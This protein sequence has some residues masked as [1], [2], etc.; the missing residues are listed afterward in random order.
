[1]SDDDYI[2]KPSQDIYDFYNGFIFSKDNFVFNK[3]I[4]KVEIY[5]LIKL[6]VGDIVEFGVFK[7]SGLA[8]WM[9]L[10]NLYEPHSLMKIIGFDYFDAQNLL[11]DLNGD[12]KKIMNYVV[13]R[14]DHVDL[15]KETI[16]KKLSNINSNSYIL[17][18]GEAVQQCSIYYNKNQGARIKLLYM[19][20]DLGEP[21]YEIL[22]ILWEKVVKDGIIVFDEYGYHRFDESNG[23]D[24]FLKDMKGKYEIFNTFV[25]HPSMYI[26]KIAY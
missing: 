22:K 14:V 7:G 1:M 11:N 2:V 10:K 23:V 5:S 8:L 24:K 25:N 19:D 9:K 17:I 6:L 3:L 16:D 21:T 26:K 20:L 4:K 15:K 13:D 12:N 18:K